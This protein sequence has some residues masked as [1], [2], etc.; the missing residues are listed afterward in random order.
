M[1][2]V[3]LFYEN[4][5]ICIPFFGYDKFL[6]TR[7]L[8]SRLCRWDNHFQRFTLKQKDGTTLIERALD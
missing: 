6:F 5:G 7:I 8:K 1:D 3:Y 2:V 4:D